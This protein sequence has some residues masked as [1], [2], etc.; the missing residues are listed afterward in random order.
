[1]REEEKRE[2]RVEERRRESGC[3][4]PLFGVTVV[5]MSKKTL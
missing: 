5:K 3:E 1:M 4:E 2:R